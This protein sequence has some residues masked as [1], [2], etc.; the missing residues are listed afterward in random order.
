MFL[1]HPSLLTPST[2][3]VH[4]FFVILFYFIVIHN[5]LSAFSDAHRNL[6]MWPSVAYA[7]VLTN[8]MPQWH[9]LESF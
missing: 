4:V 3:Q 9:K 2:F 7:T 1:S 5:P 8:F 6:V